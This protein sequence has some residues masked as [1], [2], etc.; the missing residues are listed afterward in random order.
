MEIQTQ[1]TSVF[2]NT[3]EHTSQSESSISV[4]IF[5][6]LYDV[7]D[8]NIS[9]D[10]A[11]L[12]LSTAHTLSKEDSESE[13]GMS[14]PSLNSPLISSISDVNVPTDP[15]DPSARVTDIS[16][17]HGFTIVGDNLDMNV[18]R[19]HT[20]IKQQTRSLHY[21]QTYAVKDR[22]NLSHLTDD[23]PQ[24]IPLVEDAV[25]KLIPTSNETDSLRD[26][27][28]ILLAQFLCDYLTYFKDNF[29]DVVNYHILHI[30]SMG[31][32]HKSEVVS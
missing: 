9:I 7:E 27:F 16:S 2:I 8:M 17:W 28:I 21:F 3:D 10:S 11:Q 13:D 4:N 6:G 32:S 31:I 15:Q 20:R 23:K 12:D 26:D 18:H 30:H 1:Q 22:V 29:K 19:R 14:M 5:D 25:K 24:S